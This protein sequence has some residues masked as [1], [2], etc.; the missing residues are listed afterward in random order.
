MERHFGM[1]HLKK[2]ELR[3]EEMDQLRMHHPTITIVPATALQMVGVNE[4]VGPQVAVVISDELWRYNTMKAKYISLSA[5]APNKRIITEKMWTD[6]VWTINWTKLNLLAAFFF[7]LL[8]M[9]QLLLVALKLD[10][11]VSLS[12]WIVLLP[13]WSLMLCIVV[14]YCSLFFFYWC[15][16]K[17]V[18]QSVG[19]LAGVLSFRSN[20]HSSSNVTALI[21]LGSAQFV[22]VAVRVQN[23]SF[24][25]FLVFSPMWLFLLIYLLIWG[26]L[27]KS[28]IDT[29]VELADV[30][31]FAIHFAVFLVSGIQLGLLC[32]NLENELKVSW[33]YILV[34]LWVM[35]GVMIVVSVIGFILCITSRQDIA[36]TSSV[37]ALV[38]TLISATICEVVAVMKMNG[39][40]D[41]SWHIVFGLMY[42]DSVVFGAIIQVAIWRGWKKFDL[43]TVDAANRKGMKW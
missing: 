36:S 38:I 33:S 35:D 1:K 27:L 14:S 10:E 9:F 4:G 17:T 12:W 3:E 5:T 8:V 23:F 43:A 15:G 32:W 34:P 7:P 31:T 21:L 39:T 18:Y 37:G 11:T 40:L 29:Y 30:L 22:S 41:I 24:N 2:K 13:V 19:G 42:V 25:W 20:R 26:S 16:Y 28:K 6:R